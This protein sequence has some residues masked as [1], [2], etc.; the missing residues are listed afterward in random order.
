M[1]ETNPSG[2]PNQTAQRD[3]TVEQ[4][5]TIPASLTQ[6]SSF[7]AEP[8]QPSGL[9]LFWRFGLYLAALAAVLMVLKRLFR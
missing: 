4:F 3:A 2:I 7:A 8:D 1:G 5:N 6:P 9:S